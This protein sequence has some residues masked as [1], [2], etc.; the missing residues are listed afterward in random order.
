M[1]WTDLRLRVR[2]LA[3][4]RRAES[5]LDDELTFHLE[6]EARKARLAGLPAGE[7]RRRARVAFG[8]VEQVRERCRDARGLS[9]LESLARDFRYAFRVLRHS[10]AFTAA[11][12]LSL[13]VGI[14]ATTA[15]FSLVDAVLLKMLPVRDPQQLVIATWSNKDASDLMFTRAS[16]NNGGTNVFSWQAFTDFRSRSQRLFDV[17]GFSPMG[18]INASISGEARIAGALL[19]SGNYFSGLGVGTVLGRP[20][21]ADDD[22]AGGAPAAVISYRFWERAFGQD[23]SILGRTGVTPRDFFGVSVGGMTFLREIEITLPILAQETLEEKSGE[24]PRWFD[25]DWF[26]IQVMARARRPGD[27]PAARAELAGLL[28]ADLPPSPPSEGR[29]P[30]VELQP[31]DQGIGSAKETLRDPLLILFAVTGLTLMMACANLAGLLLA[32]AAARRKEICLRLSLG[33]ARRRII[34]QLLCEGALIAAGGA[35][36]GLLLA[37]WGVRALLAA[38]ASGQNPLTLEAAPDVRVLAFAAGVSV[39][40]T[41]LFAL[42]PA[43]R[44]TGVDLSEGMKQDAGGFRR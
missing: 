2:A 23:P 1:G 21:V 30:R 33:A 22:N 18:R 34:R 29:A 10:P 4:R 44:A 39:L 36:A 5:E 37:W 11:A 16:N 17:F 19:V 14:G 8:G 6:M 3:S 41:L 26:W 20:I 9:F 28:A 35:L 31:G 40:A 32:R 38:V 43:L 15:I 27:V 42:A 24:P 25:R 13:A 7:A 12:V